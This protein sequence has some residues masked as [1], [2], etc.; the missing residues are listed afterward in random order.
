MKALAQSAQTF[1]NKCVAMIPLTPRVDGGSGSMVSVETEGYLIF[2]GHTKQ[3]DSSQMD[4]AATAAYNELKSFAQFNA[5]NAKEYS[6]ALFIKG[7]KYASDHPGHN[8]ANRQFV[9]F[10]LKGLSGWLST[11]VVGNGESDGRAYVELSYDDASRTVTAVTLG[12]HMIVGI[13]KW[14]VTTTFK[15][16][17]GIVY[18][19]TAAWEQRNGWL[20]DQGFWHGSGLD[21]MRSVWN[22][23]LNAVGENVQ[24]QFPAG[25]WWKAT[26]SEQPLL[27]PSNSPNPWKG[28]KGWPASDQ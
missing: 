11:N 20:N 1:Q 24:K 14:H 28:K 13:R 4:E 19:K 12:N 18:L 22:N 26:S 10:T 9:G 7:A 25:S 5:A 27:R 17:Q 3:E 2:E 15:D 6:D 8:L 23:H 16:G 21:A